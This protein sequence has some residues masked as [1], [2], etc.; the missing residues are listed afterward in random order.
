MYTL[1][2]IWI[3]PIKSLGGIR[4]T[5]AMVQERSLQ[6]DRRWMIVDS[7]SRFVTQRTVRQMALIDVEKVVNGFEVKHR[8]DPSTSF[9][10]PLKLV[11][12]EPVKVQVWDDEVEAITVS[13]EADALLST[14]LGQPVRLVMMPDWSNRPVDPDYAQE[15][16]NVSFADGY[17][18]LVIGQSSLDDLNARLEKPVTMHRFRPNL[19]VEGSEPY[20]EDSWRNLRIGK[21]IF[22]GVKACSRCILTTIDP[23]TG[24]KGTE[25]LKTLATYRKRNNKIYFGQNLLAHP[26]QICLGDTVEIL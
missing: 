25:P 21:T 20:A 19:V 12:N 6:Y 1:S 3:Y 2:E 13:H 5:E 14:W 22:R 24:E 15:G 17:P 4:L 9:F 11:S 10:L 26:G 7:T 16:E 18:L 8:S 23:A